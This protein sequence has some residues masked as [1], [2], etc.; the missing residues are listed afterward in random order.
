MNS[1]IDIERRQNAKRNARLGY[2]ADFFAG[3]LCAIINL[4][5]GI[6]DIMK[7][8]TVR[9]V[10]RSVIAVVATVLVIGIAGGCENGFLPLFSAMVKMAA[11]CGVSFILFKALGD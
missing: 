9:F 1:Y 3:I 6:S 4:F 7:D 2:V 8:D 11:V 10:L 5:N